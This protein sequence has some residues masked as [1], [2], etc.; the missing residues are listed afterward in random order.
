MLEMS[1]AAVCAAEAH[2]RER[3]R[4]P[5][6]H[7]RFQL[8]QCT[9][10]V[11]LRL[12]FHPLPGPEDAPSSEPAGH[13]YA[14]P[15]RAGFGDGAGGPASAGDASRADG[16]GNGGGL[17]SADSLAKLQLLPHLRHL[18]IRPLRQHQASCLL[19]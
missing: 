15:R 2:A 4:L 16:S 14:A 10:L 18:D 3:E 5:Q 7:P 19:P 1:E 17:P 12:W 13:L 6:L 11:E 9:S 8:R